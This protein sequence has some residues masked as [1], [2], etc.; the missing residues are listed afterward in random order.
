MSGDPR[1]PKPDGRPTFT[2]AWFLWFFPH[3][4]LP[5]G[6][7]VRWEGHLLLMTY[8][9]FKPEL[10]HL[11]VIIGKGNMKTVWEAGLADWHLVTVKAPRVYSGAE[12]L[13]QAKELFSFADHFATSIPTLARKLAVKAATLEIRLRGGTVH[14]RL[15]VLAGDDSKEGGKKQG[16]NPTLSLADE[17]HA[18]ENDNLWTDLKSGL[19]KR[20]QSARIAKDILWWIIGKSASISTAGHDKNGPLGRELAK[21][22]GDP[23]RG[24]APLGTVETGLRVLDDGS[25]EKHPDGRLTI[26]RSPNGSSVALIW[27]CDEDDDITDMRVVKF[28][29][30]ASLKTPDMLQ[31]AFDQ[32]TLSQFKRYHAC[33][34]TEGYE[35]WIP[36]KAWPGLQSPDVPRLVSQTWEGETWTGLTDENFNAVLEDDGDMLAVNPKFRAYIES[37]YPPKTKIVGALDMARYRDSAAIVVIAWVNGRKVPRLISWRTGGH[38]NPIRYEWPEVAILLLNRTYDLRAFAADPKYSD[39]MS[40][41]LKARG[42]PMEDFPQSNERMGQADTELRRSILAGDFAHDGDPILTAHVQAGRK[43]EL[44]DKLIVVKKQETAQAPPIDGEKALSM[45]NAISAET[46]DSGS[47]YDDPE[48][49][50]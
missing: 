3:L 36:E 45:A 43:V 19:F 30:P 39:Q 28:A 49:G 42:V 34:W 14:D 25:V 48:A 7:P 37:L 20:R 47:M 13:E 40:E 50:I 21:F 31:D 29:N 16:K 33:Q 1:F 26:C 44:K 22:L 24:I 23:K 15:K 35:S 5:E 11:L 4:T 9:F 8:E 41:R 12:N 46:D 6:Y 32:L 27:A 10:Q 17:P 18:Y 2:L 38:D